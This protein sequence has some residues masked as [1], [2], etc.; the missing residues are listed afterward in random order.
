MAPFVDGDQGAACAMNTAVSG[1][2]MRTHVFELLPSH[3][4]FAPVFQVRVRA[5]HGG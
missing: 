4:E 1:E 2:V 5:T 3:A